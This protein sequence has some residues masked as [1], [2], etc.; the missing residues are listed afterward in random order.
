MRIL[1]FLILISFG[2]EAIGQNAACISAPLPTTPSGPTWMGSFQDF[3][4]ED[5][6]V[7]IWREPCS[8]TEAVLLMT[9]EPTS[10]SPPF[11]CSSQFLVVTGGQQFDNFNLRTDPDLSDRFCNDLLV[12]T[13]FAILQD[14]FSATWPDENAFSLFRRGD[15][16]LDAGAY[17]PN[18]YGIGEP[19]G[20]PEL[21]GALSG[22]WFEPARSGEGFVLEFAVTNSGPVATI[23]WFTHFD[24]R[25]FWLIGTEPYAEGDTSISFELLEVSGTGFGA[26]FDPDE[27]VVDA[28]GT[29]DLSFEDCTNATANWESAF[30]LGTGTFDL[31][32]IAQ[33]L[34]G[35]ACE[36]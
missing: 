19:P 4:G 26:N 27:V 2:G 25:Q 35:V 34:D 9:V 28:W 8:E 1:L 12:T 5:A 31:T 15:P 22:S 17:D 10:S 16:L 18:D 21:Q 13:T 6:D 11:I 24:D 32:R 23:Y 7:T 33:T 20:P 29:L 3:G 30:G 14:Q 36:Q